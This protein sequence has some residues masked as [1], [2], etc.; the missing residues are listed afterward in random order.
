MPLV[1][2][3]TKA[4]FDAAY[5]KGAEWDSD[6]PNNRPEVMLHYHRDV[7]RP[8]CQVRAD[9]L[10]SEFQWPLTTRI[11][12]VG[13]GFGWTA[14]CFEDA[15]YTAVVS[16]DISLYVQNNK[17]GTE[18]AE[19]NAAISAVGLDP[20]TGP[21]LALKNKRFDGGV[22]ARANNGVHDENLSNNGSRNRIRSVLGDIDVAISEAVLSTL[23]DVEAVEVSSRAHAINNTLDVIHYVVTLRDGRDPGYN[24]KTLEDWK[25]LIPA[26]TFVEAGT[27]RVL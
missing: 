19:I 3:D 21:G 5:R 11:L 9:G 14:E 6:R 17:A 23:T 10:I 13:A 18:E 15:G 1:S 12:I 26:D 4:D 22:R 20:A 2:F 27:F 8:T 7:M 25:L 16:T 24:W